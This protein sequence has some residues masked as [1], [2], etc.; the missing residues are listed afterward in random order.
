MKHIV[1]ELKQLTIIL[2]T[3]ALV[4]MCFLRIHTE[5]VAA[6][7]DT[8]VT[9]SVGCQ[10]NLKGNEK[11]G[12][13]KKKKKITIEERIKQAC[14]RHNV[15]YRL[16]LAISKLETGHFKSYAYRAKNNPGGLSKNERPISFAT[17]EQGVE[18]FISNLDK[19]YIRKGL[20]TPEKIGRKYCPVNPRWAYMVRSLM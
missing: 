15:P 4:F 19:N 14:K 5:V 20:D 2:M 18:A 9:I 8:N 11:K 1:N 7:I 16:A 12:I 3:I 6:Y 13:K 17:I 10:D